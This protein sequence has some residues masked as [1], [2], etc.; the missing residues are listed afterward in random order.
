MLDNTNK[1][2]YKVDEE[3]KIYIVGERGV[4][5]TSFFNLFFQWNIEKI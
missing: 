3:N 2:D 1:E 5:K 4:G